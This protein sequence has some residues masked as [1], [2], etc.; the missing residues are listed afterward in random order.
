[1]KVQEH[2]NPETLFIKISTETV[3]SM[4]VTRLPL[5]IPPY[6]LASTTVSLYLPTGK[7]SM[8]LSCCREQANTARLIQEPVFMKA[9]A[10]FTRCTWNVGAKN[11][12][13]ITKDYVSSSVQ[14]WRPELA[15]QRLLYHG[16]LIYTSEKCRSR[17]Y[18]TGK[19][20]QENRCFQCTFLFSG[21]NLYTWTHLKTDSFDPEQNSPAAYPTMRT[22]NVGLNITF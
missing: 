7:D 9:A 17:I 16:C 1:M 18:I 5:A 11:A 19:H 12:I 20:Q 13:I 2:R 21:N 15:A 6:C 14:Q 8:F 10:T 3:S 22:Y 4:T